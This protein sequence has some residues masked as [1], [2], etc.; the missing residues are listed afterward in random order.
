[1]LLDH[2]LYK[3][4]DDFFRLEYC[5]LWEAIVLGDKAELKRACMS[6]NVGPAYALFTSVLTLKPFEDIISKDRSRL[7]SKASNADREM[8][9]VYASK[10]Y[11]DIALMLGRAD[12]E[13]LLLLKTN[14]CLRHIDKLLGAPAPEKPK[15]E[16]KDGKDKKAGGDKEKDKFSPTPAYVFAGIFAALWLLGRLLEPWLIR[17]LFT[18]QLAG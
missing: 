17:R 10:Y 8:L 2:G 3:N 18:R 16:K 11:G 9:K 6:L 4:L 15:D 13:L 7:Q 12:S 1:M 5:R 14:D